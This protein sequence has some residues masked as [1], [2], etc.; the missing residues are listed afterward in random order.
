MEIGAI[1]IL[2]FD[3]GSVWLLSRCIIHANQTVNQRDIGL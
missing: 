1:W 3:V 2:E